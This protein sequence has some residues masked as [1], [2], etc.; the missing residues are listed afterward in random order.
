MTLPDGWSTGTVRANGIQIHYYE[1]G[2]GQPILAAHGMYDDGRRWLPLGSDLAAEH[3]VVAYDARGHGQSDAPE[4]GY[5]LDTRVEDLVGLADALGLTD[6][7]LLGHSMGGATAAW[8][9]ARQPELPRGLVLE[10]PARF[11]GS[12]GIDLEKAREITRERLRESKA[13]SI[14]ER[15]EAEFDDTDLAEAQR[16]RLAASVEECSPHIA[17]IAQQHPPVTDAFD[18]I[19]CPTLVLKRDAEVSDR[20]ADLDAADQLADGRLVHIPGAGHY[21]FRD[22]SDAANTELRTFLRRKVESGS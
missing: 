9:A 17:N 16:R 12:P 3:R 10:D 1:V 22:A 19:S 2:H 15:I 8:T 20:V 4:T 5:D 13:R 11:H 6:P 21:V 14:E 7:L 18:D